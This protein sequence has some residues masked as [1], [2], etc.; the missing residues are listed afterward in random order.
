MYVI[1]GT[2]VSSLWQTIDREHTGNARICHV[3]FASI[4]CNRFIIVSNLQ[5]EGSVSGARRGSRLPAFG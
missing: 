4:V 3:Y 1:D 2:Q 5:R